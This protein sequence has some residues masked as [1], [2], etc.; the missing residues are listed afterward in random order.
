L[1]GLDIQV[2]GEVNK[3]LQNGGSGVTNPCF[4]KNGNWN[5]MPNQLV[6]IYYQFG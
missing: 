4:S 3:I 6:W 5:L 1:D 2:M